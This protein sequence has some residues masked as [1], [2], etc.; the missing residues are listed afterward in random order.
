MVVVFWR[1][2]PATRDIHLQG[3]QHQSGQCQGLVPLLAKLDEFGLIAIPQMRIV[4]LLS[5]DATFP[6]SRSTFW[7][8]VMPGK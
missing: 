7:T 4:R 8:I 3:R 5:C 1:R 6:L 2:Q